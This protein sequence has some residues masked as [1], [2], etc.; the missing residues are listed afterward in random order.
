[1]PGII[2]LPT[3]AWYDAIETDEYGDL[4][5]SGNPNVLTIDIGTSLLGQGPSSHSCLVD[6]ERYDGPLIDPRTSKPPPLNE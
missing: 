6:I 3:G 2:Q 5:L 4:E 1:M